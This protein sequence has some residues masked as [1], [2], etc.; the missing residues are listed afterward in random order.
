MAKSGFSQK[1]AQGEYRTGN[2]MFNIFTKPGGRVA[3]LQKNVYTT[4]W[5]EICSQNNA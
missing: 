3:K 1:Q 2:N 4:L 5:H